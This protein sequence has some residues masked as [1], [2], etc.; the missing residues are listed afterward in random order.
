MSAPTSVFSPSQSC[1][2]LLMLTPVRGT[3]IKIETQTNTAR[4]AN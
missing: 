1:A 2:W 4:D 3:L